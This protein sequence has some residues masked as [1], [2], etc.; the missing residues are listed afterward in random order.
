MWSVIMQQG[1]AEEGMHVLTW[2][3]HGW[4]ASQGGAC[5]MHACPSGVVAVLRG[6]QQVPDGAVV[7]PVRL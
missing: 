5:A 7:G 2:G 4:P 1:M 3:P 6:R